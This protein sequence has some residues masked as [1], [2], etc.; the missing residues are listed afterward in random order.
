MNTP[1]YEEGLRFE[2]T[3]CGDCCRHEPGFV[4]LS[5]R[6]LLRMQSVLGQSRR[7]IVDTHCVWVNVVGFER[8]SLREK[9]N[10]DCVFWD[11]GCTIYEGRPLQCR[12]YPFWPS[13]VASPE[14]WRTTA[15]ACPGIGR[16]AVHSREE[17]DA[18]LA[19]RES[20]PLIGDESEEWGSDESGGKGWS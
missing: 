14:T 11:A 5:E 6:D 19:E 16:G 8:L 15:A 3:K 1:F 13:A 17:I 12:T 18:R 4:F 10:Y 7:E 9:D 2:C 20:E